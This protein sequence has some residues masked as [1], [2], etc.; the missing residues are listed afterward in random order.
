MWGAAFLLIF[1]ML[2]FR[3]FGSLAS[4]GISVVVAVRVLVQ[5]GNE[6]F[7]FRLIQ[8][9]SFKILVLPFM[10]LLSI[11]LFVGI[12]IL[13]IC[14]LSDLVGAIC[15]YYWRIIIWLGIGLFEWGT[16]LLCA[17]LFFHFSKFFGDYLFFFSKL[18][19]L[20]ANKLSK[21]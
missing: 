4:W 12:S 18:L 7:A 14:F 3:N 11:D 19:K 17:T 8:K 6:S 13:L 21:A 20:L 1:V 9:E 16:S 10:H 5:W 15:V 2:E